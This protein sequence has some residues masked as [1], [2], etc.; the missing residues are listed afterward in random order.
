MNEGLRRDSVRDGDK[1]EERSKEELQKSGTRIDELETVEAQRQQT[2]QTPLE[3]IEEYRFL[4]D[5]SK[6]IILVLNKR[7]QIIFANKSTLTNFG[8][9]KEELIGKTITHFLAKGSIKK[10]LY[11]LGQEFLGRPQ[12]ELEVQATTRDGEIRYLSVAEGSAPIYENGKLIGVMISASDITERKKDEEILRKRSA[13]LELI[14]HIQSEIPMNTDI[15][16]ILIR[17]AESIGKSFGYYKISVNLYDRETNEIEYLT[18]WNKTG[19]SLPRGHRQKLGQGLIG[20]AGLAKQTIVANDVSKEP[21]Y[22]PYHLTETKAEL[23]IPLLV[24]DKLVGVLDLQATQ[25]D[26]FSKEDVAIL[27]SI[28]NY[29]AYIIDWRQ[30]EEALRESEEKFRSL[31]EQSPNM[32]FINKKGRVVYINAKCEEIMGY[33]REE[34]YSPDFDF[35]ILTA[36]EFRDRIKT[37]FSSHKKGGEVL[38]LTYALLTKEGKRIEAILATKLIDYGKEK[39]ILGIVTDITEQKRAEEAIKNSEE[40]FKMIFEYAPDA[41][42]LNDMKGSFIDGNKAAEKVTGYKREELI[43]SSFLKLRLLSLDQIPRAAALLAKNAMGRPT[44]PDEFV[45]KRKDGAKVS[46]EISTYPVKIKGK[47]LVLGIARDITERKHA[48]EALQESEEKFRSMSDSAQ[49]AILMMDHQGNISYW[50]K[51]AEKILGYSAQETLGQELHTFLAPKHYQAAFT[52]AFSQFKKIGQGPAV[53][54]MLELKTLR[55]DGTEIPIELS[56]SATKLKGQWN[57]IGMLRDITERKRVENDLKQSSLR[58]GQ[59]LGSIINV[60]GATV[61]LKDPYTAGH[62]KR[63][64]DLARSIATEMALSKD[65]IEGIRIAGIIHD[66][67]KISVPAEILSKPG[68]LNENEFYLIKNHAQV[69]YEIL[70]DIEFQW[71]IAQI[72]YQHHERMD[73]S[74]YPRGLK[75]EDIILEARILAV[76]DAVEAMASHR[77]Y[78]PALGIDKALEEISQKKGI[79]YDPDVVDVC[80]KLFSENKFKFE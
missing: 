7:G 58:L 40:R 8:Y 71:P 13:Q 21:D 45:L 3:S 51:A 66:I 68:K 37:N 77:P 20:K 16:T 43:G 29:I 56:I 65:Q 18:G 49:D 32:I 10:A 17:A 60:V 4:I 53:G 33:K 70:K 59:A 14:H 52:E 31:A 75:G 57:A 6:E 47:T 5:H 15:E 73:G 74:G 38:P 22:I 50:N 80:L 34:I 9:S 35:L 69:G 54:K 61:E 46:V 39:A 64:A 28:A 79:L 25:V 44:G 72:V 67:G 2:D 26:A 63:V 27:G 24:Q 1:T 11:A 23:I 12:R 55:K 30:R 78:R 36:P 42:Y 19:L 41:Y 48:E 76:A 62:Q